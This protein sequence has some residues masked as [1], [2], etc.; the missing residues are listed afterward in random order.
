MYYTHG[1]C[2]NALFLFPDIP[3]VRDLQ[4]LLKRQAINNVVLIACTN[5]A[6]VELLLNWHCHITRLNLTQVPF[7]F[8]TIVSDKTP[9]FNFLSD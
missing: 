2:F 3:N 9:F 5:F 4:Q 7:L 6:V 8:P 1:V